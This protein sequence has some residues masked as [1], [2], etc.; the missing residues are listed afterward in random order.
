MG[1]LLA[2]LVLAFA[3]DFKA[4]IH[5]FALVSLKQFVIKVEIAFVVGFEHSSFVSPVEA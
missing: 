1:S 5:S 3:E 2:D 4:F